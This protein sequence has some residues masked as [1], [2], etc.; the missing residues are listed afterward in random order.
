MR[1]K[2]AFIPFVKIDY[3]P[4]QIGFSYDANTSQ[5]KTASQGKGGFEISVTYAGFLDRYNSTKDAV[6]CPKF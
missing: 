1:L 6:L 2:D 3:N 4:F 5:L